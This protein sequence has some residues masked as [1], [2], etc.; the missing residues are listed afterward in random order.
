M[1]MQGVIHVDPYAVILQNNSSNATVY[2]TFDEVLDR[3]QTQEG[4]HPITVDASVVYE[5]GGTEQ[6]EL[7]WV[8]LSLLEY[9]KRGVA[10]D[11]IWIHTSVDTKIMQTVVKFR[12]LRQLIQGLASQLNLEIRSPYI[13]AETSLKMFA[14]ADEQNNML[15]GLYAAVGAVWGG[16]DGLIIHGYDVLS[17][18]SEHGHRIAQNM[19]AVLKEESGL[20]G[21][22][23]P[24]FGSYQVEQ[25]T[26]HQVHRYGLSLYLV[27]KEGC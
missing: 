6:E 15:R 21:W 7:L 8:L 26:Q 4:D 9:A 11:S 27:Q 12:A 25:Q 14:K 16:A 24:L 19:H 23:D 17:S 1:W 20:D 3:L 22:C 13:C 10:W 5:L 2:S 18:S